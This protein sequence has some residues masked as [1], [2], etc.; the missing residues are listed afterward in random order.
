[1][2]LVAGGV[3]VGDGVGE[4]VAV[5]VGPEARWGWR[6]LRGCGVEDVVGGELA[7]AGEG[8]GVEGGLGE[9]DVALLDGFARRGGETWAGEAPP[10]SPIALAKRPRARGEAIWALTEMEP[11]DSP[12]M[13]TLSGSPP[14][15]AMFFW[16]QA[17]A[18]V[19]S[20]RP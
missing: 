16:T 18:A 1:M 17:R 11:A 3:D 4:E 10:L 2:G 12:K 14:K 9:G 19:W 13:V 15:A 5:E 6:G 8:G 20:R 7:E